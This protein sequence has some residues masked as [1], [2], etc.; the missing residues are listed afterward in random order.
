MNAIKCT[1]TFPV[2][3]FVDREPSANQLGVFKD[4]CAGF[5]AALFHVEMGE[6]KD[7]YHL[8]GVVQTPR[9]VGN[10]R[11]SLC[12]CFGVP[13]RRYKDLDD[14]LK[15]HWIVCKKVSYMPGAIAYI[16]KEGMDRIV[17]VGYQD[18]WIQQQIAEGARM[19][20]IKKR[21]GVK[22]M[23]DKNSQKMINAFLD[24]SGFQF[25]P[26]SP[27][28]VLFAMVDAGISVWRCKNFKPCYAEI[29][30]QRT[31]DQRLFDEVIMRWML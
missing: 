21:D 28:A 1:I 8:E 25:D 16:V 20:A 15:K 3:L 22:I 4:W 12:G 19:H 7:N 18:T 10:I 11:Q 23:T 29:V 13:A 27:R 31:G 2:E 9:S 5:D 26:V 14:M 17:Q 6:E 30:Y 24:D